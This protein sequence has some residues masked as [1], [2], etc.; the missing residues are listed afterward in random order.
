MRIVAVPVALT[1]DGSAIGPLT[2]TV[3][4][5]RSAPAA[6]ATRNTVRRIIGYRPRRTWDLRRPVNRRRRTLLRVQ[7]LHDRFHPVEPRE[8]NLG[9]IEQILQL[10]NLFGLQGH[11]DL[12]IAA[13]CVVAEVL[14]RLLL[15]R[16]RGLI[17]LKDFDLFANAIEDDIGIPL[18][19]LLSDE[20]LQACSLEHR[21]S[22][23]FHIRDVRGG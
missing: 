5:A 2:V 18:A 6:H 22:D 13:I 16:D 21:E 23:G 4:W 10:A 15:L 19:G 20:L 8:W 3:A 1:S 7:L 11:F 9:V 17:G 12:R 14:V